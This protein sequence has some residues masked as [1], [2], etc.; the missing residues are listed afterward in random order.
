MIR[1]NHKGL[2]EIIGALAI[3]TF[4]TLLSEHS[5]EPRPNLKAELYDSFVSLR[6]QNGELSDIPAET[7]VGVYVF[8]NGKPA[9]GKIDYDTETGLA[10]RGP[11][12]SGETIDIPSFFHLLYVAGIF[13]LEEKPDGRIVST[14]PFDVFFGNVD[15]VYILDPE[16][17][18]RESDESDN[19]VRWEMP[20]H[21]IYDYNRN[22]N[23]YRDGMAQLLSLEREIEG[24]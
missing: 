16:N 20:F 18:L 9:H 7:E 15:L 14:L 13:E 11:I 8:L 23:L 4:P 19:V 6:V 3:M 22:L 21:F 17:V 1:R 12:R 2:A 10:Y 5:P 24:D